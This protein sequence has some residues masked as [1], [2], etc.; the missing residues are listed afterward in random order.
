MEALTPEQ[1][2]EKYF[3]ESLD[4]S[5]ISDELLEL[6]GSASEISK[7]N[8]EKRREELQKMSSQELAKAFGLK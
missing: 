8:K 2:L 1:F 5:S 4:E 7:E 6:K 3:G